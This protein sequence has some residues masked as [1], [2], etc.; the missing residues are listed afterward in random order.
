M[1]LGY[2]SFT[3]N[4]EGYYLL[5]RTRSC[6]RNYSNGDKVFESESFEQPESQRLFTVF[7]TGL[8]TMSR[9]QWINMSLSNCVDNIALVF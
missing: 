8:L 6:Q 5:W 9:N 4:N 3:L 1:S 2:L 7:K